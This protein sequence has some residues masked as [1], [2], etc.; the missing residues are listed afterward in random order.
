MRKP[1][2]ISVLLL[3]IIFANA[4]PTILVWDNDKGGT[5]TDPESNDTVGTE[6]AIKNTLLNCSEVTDVEVTETL[7][8]ELSSYRAIFVLNGFYP[9]TGEITPNE[10]DKLVDYI[11]LGKSVY[12]EGGDFG[13]DYWSTELFSKFDAVFEYDGRIYT[14]GNVDVVS[15][16]PSTITEGLTFT[17][18]AYQVELPDNYVDELSEGVDGQMIFTSNR[19]GVRT[20]G[21]CTYTTDGTS[22]LIYSSFIF[23]ALKNG[24]GN[25]TK[26]DLMNLYISNMDLDANIQ[27]VSLSMIKSIFG[28]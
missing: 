23:G 10:Q 11:E 3:L 18:Y 2:Q 5:F 22:T 16:V 27:P 26:D 8:Q 17:Y 12:I 25:N 4:S 19:G 13:N 21:R 20:N 28:K 14:D 15:G 6:Y 1:V 7:P 9:Y 24:G